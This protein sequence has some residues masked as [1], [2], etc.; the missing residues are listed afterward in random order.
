MHDDVNGFGDE[1]V[2]GTHRQ[3][4]CGVGQLTDKAQ[5]RQRLARGAGVDGGEALHARRQCQK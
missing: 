5:T 1:C 4:A 2:Q 3:F